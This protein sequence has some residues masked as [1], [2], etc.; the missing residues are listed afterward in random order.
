MRTISISEPVWQA[1]AGVGKFGESEDDV[2]RRVF[3][4]PAASDA[5]VT[6]A[7]SQS[8]AP[9][10]VRSQSN[11]RRSFATDRMSSY[12]SGNELRVSFS[13][14]P[15]SSWKLPPKS[16]KASIRAVRDQATGFAKKHGATLGQI[17]AVK[18]TLTDTGY[19]LLR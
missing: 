18:K 8:Q 17:N 15:S 9:V 19:Y 11:S 12:I 1:I 6:Q 5:K 4:I 13:S 3:G 2:L 14:G 7:L 16:D 10:P